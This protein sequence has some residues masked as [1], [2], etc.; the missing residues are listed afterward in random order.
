M[1]CELQ[2]GILGEESPFDVDAA[3]WLL[4]DESAEAVRCLVAPIIAVF[5]MR[6][7]KWIKST[8]L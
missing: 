3:D 4:S 2:V 5:V 1:N 8:R 7:K 6:K